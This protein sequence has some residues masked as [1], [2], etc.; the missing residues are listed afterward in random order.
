MLREVIRQK[1]L[2]LLSSQDMKDHNFCKILSFFLS[3][4]LFLVDA[5]RTFIGDLG[6][7]FVAEGLE[8]FAVS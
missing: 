5:V 1:N 3:K 2:D 6:V 8:E 7:E 4:M